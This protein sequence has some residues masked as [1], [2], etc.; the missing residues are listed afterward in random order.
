MAADVST[1]DL[2]AANRESL[3]LA[4]LGAWLH[5]MGK[6]LDAFVNNESGYRY[7]V[8]YSAE[9]LRAQLREIAHSPEDSYWYNKSI[10]GG[11]DEWPGIMD[12]AKTAPSSLYATLTADGHHIPPLLDHEAR[13]SVGGMTHTFTVR[14]LILFS[15][16]GFIFSD[17]FFDDNLVAHLKCRDKGLLHQYLGRAHGAAHIEK[18]DSEG[19]PQ[20]P[21]ALPS[22]PFGIEGDVLAGLTDRMR[23]LLAG[24]PITAGEFV[25]ERDPSQEM[26]V[27]ARHVSRVLQDAIADRRRPINEVTLWDWGHIAA[28]L[29]KAALAGAV[30]DGRFADP[31]TLQWRLLFVRFDGARVVEHVAAIPALLARKKWLGD[32]LDRVRR[33][34][35][36]QYPLGTEVYRDENGAIFVVPDLPDLIDMREHS[37]GPSL[38]ALI[39]HALGFDGE[40]VVTPQLDRE[41]WWAQRPVLDDPRGRDQLPPIG[42]RLSTTVRPHADPQAVRRWWGEAPTNAF[43]CAV[44][45]VRPQGSGVAAERKMSSYWLQRVN[46]RAKE[47]WDNRAKEGVGPTIWIDEV[48]DASGRLCVVAG[49]FALDVWLTE[50]SMI[51]SIRATLRPVADAASGIRPGD[52]GSRPKGC[53]PRPPAL[54]QHACVVR[55]AALT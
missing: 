39:A 8:I 17:P 9:E 31:L 14:Q 41:A 23:V 45:L 26:N 7:K 34:L 24:L 40:L 25:K 3:L 4:E 47:W 43:P 36:W 49:R 54:P 30:L 20:M 52:S 48:A 1:L 5:D 38:R 37:Q 46:G 22:S 44:S 16:P 15:E 11:K 50:P 21:V 2:L 42:A 29:Y 51:S 12:E 13:L 19:G 53:F 32:G 6:G 35:E 28:A 55:S 18:E 33:L 27:V 10:E